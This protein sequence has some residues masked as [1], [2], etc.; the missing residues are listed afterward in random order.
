MPVP[1]QPPPPDG[2]D[3][4]SVSAPLPFVTENEIRLKYID[5]QTQGEVINLKSALNLF[6]EEKGP[7]V[8]HDRHGHVLPP[9]KSLLQTRL[10][11]IDEY[12]KVHKLK[13]NQNKTKI[14]SFNFSH[15][16]DFLPKMSIGETE[17]EVVK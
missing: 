11:Q 14:M 15:K 5:D 16:F 4:V 17:L 6:S 12:A 10:N 2:V 9:E 7:R 13:I 3:V 1:P 8:Y